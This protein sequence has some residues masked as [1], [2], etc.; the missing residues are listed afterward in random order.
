MASITTLH[1]LSDELLLDIAELL[2]QVDLLSYRLACRRLANV[3]S[4]ILLPLAKLTRLYLHPTSIDRFIQICNGGE[5]AA[6]VRTVVLLGKPVGPDRAMDEG[7]EHLDDHPWPHFVHTAGTAATRPSLVEILRNEN[8]PFSVAYGS[9]I[10]AMV[11]LANLRTIAYTALTDLPGLNMTSQADIE[12]CRQSNVGYSKLFGG[13]GQPSLTCAKRSVRWSDPEVM[14]GLSLHVPSPL[15][16]DIGYGTVDYLMIRMNYERLA[17]G[18]HSGPNLKK[19]KDGKPSNCSQDCELVQLMLDRTVRSVSYTISKDH[20][21]CG[22]NELADSILN[23][24]HGVEDVSASIDHKSEHKRDDTASDLTMKCLWACKNLRSLRRFKMRG[25]DARPSVLNI[26]S[27]QLS[28]VDESISVDDLL[29]FVLQH[30]QTLS[31]FHLNNVALTKHDGVDVRT[32]MMEGLKV[33]KDNLPNLEEASIVLRRTACGSDCPDYVGSASSGLC[34]PAEGVA[35]RLFRASDIEAVAEAV[36]VE[37]R[38]GTWDFG[39]YLMRGRTARVSGPTEALSTYKTREACVS[40]PTKTLDGIW[41]SLCL[42][43]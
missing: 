14:I 26:G 11:K 29:K 4:T 22:W 43:Q 18:S 17:A 30:G 27:R 24:C 8:T 12:S 31:A 9:L 3:G 42:I 10:A 13:V 40:G 35:S 28:R 2:L 6:G 34:C 21:Q 33:L 41:K 7:F 37:E 36:G 39:E 20:Y 32:G 16:M 25:T 15:H 19:A 5:F 1:H 38:D 23:S